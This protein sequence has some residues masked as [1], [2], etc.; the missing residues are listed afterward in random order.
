M[1]ATK[2]L[3]IH[4]KGTEEVL[5]AS[6]KVLCCSSG[7]WAKSPVRSHMWPC[8]FCRNCQKHAQNIDRFLFLRKW[9][10]KSIPLTHSTSEVD[11]LVAV[12]A[13][14]AKLASIQTSTCSSCSGNLTSGFSDMAF[15]REKRQPEA[16]KPS[17]LKPVS[18]TN[19]VGGLCLASYL[20]LDPPQRLMTA[21]H[22][23]SSLG[24]PPQSEWDFIQKNSVKCG[25]SSSI[26]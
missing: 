6:L 24:Y 18:T 26:S 11:S 4:R 3:P 19:K 5:H 7:S 22:I 2:A 23:T 12:T 25:G 20:H 8:E 1:K 14:T 17:S 21:M 16:S 15:M 10:G 9:V 13:I